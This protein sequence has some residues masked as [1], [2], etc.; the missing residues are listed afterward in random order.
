M[1]TPGQKAHALE[2]L[3]KAALRFR[4]SQADPK[5]SHHHLYRGG[6]AELREFERRY[7]KEHG[8]QVYGEVVGKVAR[9]QASHERG[10]V[11]LEHVQG[12]ISFSREGRPERVRPHLA[13]VHAAPHSYGHHSGRCDGACRKG[14]RTHKH[15]R[16]SSTGG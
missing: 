7:G 15:R 14:A 8:R 10:G 16:G 6:E 3:D 13:Y 12:H 1:L 5:A 11:K 2:N 9:E 4:L